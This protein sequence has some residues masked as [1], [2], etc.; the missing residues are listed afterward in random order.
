MAKAKSV[1]T[2]AKKKGRATS[3]SAKGKSPSRD[4]ATGRS[5]KKAQAERAPGRKVESS[6]RAA[7]RPEAK[8]SSP[9]QASAGPPALARGRGKPIVHGRP[10]VAAPPP[11]GKAARPASRRIKNAEL[12][13]IRTMLAQKKLALTSHIQAEL[14]ELEKPEKRHRADLEEIASDTHDTDSLCEIMDIE[15]SQI[16]QIDMAL[17]K[18]D[19]GTYG[20]CEDCGGE[21]PLARLEAL[22]FATQCIDCKRKAEFEGQISGSDSSR[23]G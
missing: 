16:D 23:L 5:G 1:K 10:I 4:S 13:R 14:S 22:P 18:I 7:A 19:N 11:K 12:Q 2:D 15:A 9:G 6:G 3:S 17:T 20:I 21:I 8:N